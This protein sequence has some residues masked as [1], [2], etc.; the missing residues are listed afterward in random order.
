MGQQNL[1]VRRLWKE[2]HNKILP[3]KIICILFSGKNNTPANTLLLCCSK[4]LLG[5][6]SQFYIKHMYGNMKNIVIFFLITV[7]YVC[8]G[9]A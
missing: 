3:G 4:L 5:R 2:I 6:A 8:A 7:R 1:G 9:Y